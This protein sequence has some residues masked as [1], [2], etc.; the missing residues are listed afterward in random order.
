MIEHTDNEM[1]MSNNKTSI[2]VFKKDNHKSNKNTKKEVDLN[3]LV[4][5]MIVKSED[6]PKDKP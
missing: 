2:N 4:N 6:K 5:E 1:E 3:K